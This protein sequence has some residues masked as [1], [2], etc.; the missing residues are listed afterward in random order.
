M[1]SYW[2]LSET[3][4]LYTFHD[5]QKHKYL[6]SFQIDSDK[7]DICTTCTI[8]FPYNNDLMEYWVPGQTTFALI[9][10]VYD[11]YIYHHQP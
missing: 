3:V 10:G 6:T 11:S 2:Q 5:K 9:G 7:N 4:F 1:K 8:S